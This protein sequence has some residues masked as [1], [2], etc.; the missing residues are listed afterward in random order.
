MHIN[1]FGPP[2]WR[3]YAHK[4]TRPVI[5][6]SF[7]LTVCRRDIQEP[8]KKGETSLTVRVRNE[9]TQ[10][11]SYQQGALPNELADSKQFQERKPISIIFLLFI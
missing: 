3:A 6:K 4:L 10:P 2:Q 9:R 11:W 5:S 1:R 8:K 7:T